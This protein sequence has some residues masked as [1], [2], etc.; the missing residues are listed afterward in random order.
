MATI[1]WR[2]KGRW[3]ARERIPGYS[4]KSR[5]CDTRG[6]AQVWAERV[7][8]RLRAGVDTVSNVATESSLSE[9]LARCEQEV[10][11]HKRGHEQERRRI[12]QWRQHAFAQ[13]KLSRITSQQLVQFR[14][15]RLQEGV[16]ATTIRL[17]LPLT[18]HLFC[19][20]RIEWEMPYPT[21]PV[22][23]LR[24]PQPVKG[25][26]RRLDAEETERFQRDRD[27]RQQTDP[28]GETIRP[29]NRSAPRETREV[30]LGRR[31][32]RA[33]GHDSARHQEWERRSDR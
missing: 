23:H 22:A 20:A 29:R 30:H 32:P 18:S 31:R 25:R 5:T 14:D 7:K 19:I 24:R 26:D 11:P 4:S 10:T 8:R 13:L 17:D 16:A 28:A 27:P 1:D 3:R 15:Q 12:G 9:A 21:N 33:S 6:E 2:G